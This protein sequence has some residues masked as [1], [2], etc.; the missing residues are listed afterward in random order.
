MTTLTL[1]GRTYRISP[2]GLVWSAYT[3]ANAPGTLWK[4][5]E[6]NSTIS[7]LV[8][9]AAGVEAPPPQ[10]KAH[11]KDRYY[12]DRHHIKFRQQG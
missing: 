8:R 3:R 7:R 1:N 11:R 5:M 4:R 9:I 12:A 6:R 2:S 10:A